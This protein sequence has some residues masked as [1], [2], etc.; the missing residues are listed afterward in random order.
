MRL[1][2]RQGQ[3]PRGSPGAAVQLGAPPAARTRAST[4]TAVAL[5]PEARYKQKHAAKAAHRLA[6]ATRPGPGCWWRWR[7]PTA[8]PC[9]PGPL[10]SWERWSTAGRQ[11]CAKWHAGLPS[12]SSR[13]TRAAGAGARESGRHSKHAAGAAGAAAAAAAAAA[14]A[15]SLV[16]AAASAAAAAAAAPHLDQCVLNVQPPH[17]LGKVVQLLRL[18]CGVGA[19]SAGIATPRTQ[20]LEE[21]AGQQFPGSSCAYKTATA[22]LHP[23]GSVRSVAVHPPGG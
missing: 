9:A 12:A 5:Q 13:H 8:A 14:V 21:A 10:T 16:A 7:A 3:R 23:T 1:D 19:K 2:G 4:H 18:V 11:V 17:H 15:A 6:G 22:P 20:P